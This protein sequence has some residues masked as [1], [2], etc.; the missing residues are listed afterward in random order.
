MFRATEC[1]RMIAAAFASKAALKTS[2][3]YV[4]AVVM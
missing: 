2:R 1:V 3:G 4:A